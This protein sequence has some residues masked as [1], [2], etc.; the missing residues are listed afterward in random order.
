MSFSSKQKFE[1]ALIATIVFFFFGLLVMCKKEH[2]PVPSTQD[3]V[4]VDT[5]REKPYIITHNNKHL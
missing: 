2:L 3:T 1:V 5:V 4:K